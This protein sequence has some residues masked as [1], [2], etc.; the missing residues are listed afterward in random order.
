MYTWLQCYAN[1]AMP[2]TSDQHC[3]GQP[4]NTRVWHGQ[5]MT[6]PT[7]SR[8]QSQPFQQTQKATQPHKVTTTGC[9][10]FN[11]KRGRPSSELGAAP[12]MLRHHSQFILKD[13]TITLGHKQRC[14]VSP[15][16]YIFCFTGKARKATQC[17]LS[18]SVAHKTKCS[19]TID[20]DPDHGKVT[21]NH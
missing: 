8:L 4:G 19:L 16:L 7:I 15:L 18:F 2:C 1:S 20:E 11:K 3:I 5:L 13:K 12:H 21:E 14:K 6:Q 9:R 17:D 10:L